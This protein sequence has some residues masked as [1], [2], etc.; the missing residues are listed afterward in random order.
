[1]SIPQN[2][3]D[4]QLDTKRQTN[5]LTIFLII[6]GILTII[7]FFIFILSLILYSWSI[8]LDDCW[9]G[10]TNY[11]PDRQDLAQEAELGGNLFLGG[12]SL[13]LL[14]LISFISGLILKL[15][16]FFKKPK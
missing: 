16:K 1:M 14:S 3:Q 11:C 12:L 10:G 8:S 15:Y 13:F 2:S 4:M 9:S 6:T 5:K 7:T